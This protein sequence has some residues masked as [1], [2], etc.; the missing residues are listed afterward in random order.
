METQRHA[1]IALL[2]VLAASL[3]LSL[4]YIPPYNQ[5]LGDKEVYR[6]MGL[7]IHK[8]GVPYRDAF[9]HKPPLIYFLNYVGVLFNGWVQWLMDAV[10]VLLATFLFFRL[11][12]KYR[13]PYPWIPP[14]LFNFMLRDHLLCLGMGMTR[15]YT[16]IFV[17]LFFCILM[18]NHRFRYF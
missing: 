8:G 1:R 12:S 2:F 18:G 4:T 11:G 15:E 16:T 13:L 5:I 14:L 7:L 9:D 17:I 10:L 3:L 6:Y